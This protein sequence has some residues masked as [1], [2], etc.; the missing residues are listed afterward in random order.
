MPHT[1]EVAF[2]EFGFEALK[3]EAELQGVTIE[4]L[5]YHAAIYYLA[6]DRQKISHRV[7][8]GL[9]ELPPEEPDGPTD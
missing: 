5:V 8:R 2:D 4:E 3:R 7:P 9:G 6:G 1:V